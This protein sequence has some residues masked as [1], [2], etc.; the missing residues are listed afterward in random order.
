[1]I[2]RG[3]GCDQFGLGRERSSRKRK[4]REGYSYR[5]D[6]VEVFSLPAIDPRPVS[7]AGGSVL[8]AVSDCALEHC[9][10]PAETV[11]SIEQTV[12]LGAI[13]GPLLDLEVEVV[14]VG[15]ALGLPMEG[16]VI[17]GMARA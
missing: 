2:G 10:S 5:S 7:A 14:G 17:E 12:D 4:K 6:R 15:P 3:N 11:A 8:W 13:A 16:D 1:M 9:A